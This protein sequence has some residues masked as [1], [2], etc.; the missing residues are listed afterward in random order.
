MSEPV[1]ECEALVA[2][3]AGPV[4][5][6][7][8]FG[9]APGE[10]LGLHGR[11]GAGKST[12]LGAIAGSARVFAG[13]LRRRPGLRVAYQRQRA[14]RPAELPL[15]GRDLLRLTGAPASEA[16]EAIRPLLDLRLDRLSG[17]QF[18][19]VHTWSCLGGPAELVLL[20]EPTNNLDPT[21]TAALA[22]LV[23]EGHGRRAVL[24]VSHE[25]DFLATVCTRT[26]H[27]SP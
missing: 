21:A 10:V 2:G 14:I 16:P 4:V 24:V 6:P 11:N 25:A 23:R 5:G 22:E 20:D 19:L 9:V 12:V 3:Y 15:T 26:V 8:T 7:V 18:Q 1:L 13:S 27:L 17:G